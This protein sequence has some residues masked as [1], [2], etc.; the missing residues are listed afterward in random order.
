MRSASWNARIECGG[1]IGAG[2][3]I[4]AHHVLTCAHVVKDSDRHQVSVTFAGGDDMQHAGRVVA[5]GDWDGTPTSQG[6][7]AVLELVRPANLTPAR[8]AAPSD[9][10]GDPPP[11]LLAHGFPRHNRRGTL[12][13]YRTTADQLLDSEW[14]QL[15]AWKTYGQPLAPG[16]SG[17][18]LT[19]TDG[20][21]V[22]LVT[23]AAKDPGI[24]DGRM[25]PAHVVARY[26][27]PL[28]ELIPHPVYSP[29]QLRRLRELIE[30]ASK[31][32]KLQCSPERL[33]R[34]A[35]G[36]GPPPPNG[37]NTLWDAAWYLLFEVPDPR[38]IARFTGRLA[39]F[40]DDLG[41][42]RG[43]RAWSQAGNGSVAPPRTSR[44]PDWSPIL[45][46]I[47]PSGRG[48][49][50][51]LVEVS[52]YNGQDRLVVGSNRL[53][54]ED[55][56][57]YALERIDEAYHVLEPEARELIAFVLPLRYL[58]LDVARWQRSPDDDS[59]LGSFAPLVVIS[60]ERRRSFGLQHKLRQKWARL[61]TH[62]MA[63]LHRIGCA[64]LRQSPKS[65][66]IGLHRSTDMVG[67]G[68]PPRAEGVRQLLRATLNAPA[69]AILWPRNNC[70][71]GAAPHDDCQGTAFL[72]HLDE[73][74][75][76]RPLRDLPAYIHELR[77]AACSV[78][79]GSDSR[80]TERHWAHDLT[81]MW[82]DPRCLP[83]P[84]SFQELP[85]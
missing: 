26:W 36:I 18:A 83:D 71:G 29:S 34:D 53:P 84:D 23:S 63:Q 25:L 39:I 79:D 49:N 44:A 85:V 75:A 21:V 67:F 81:L 58:N 73:Q 10:F 77:E 3:L 28:A 64:S 15:E 69:P 6:D 9:A 70:K 52:A 74:L 72:N 45:V 27:S 60:L 40:I 32:D 35:V 5:R 17:A 13:E 37:L 55:I 19:L 38:A 42:R 78:E 46:E 14:I 20:R 7:V 66:T 16:F 11:K 2:F 22:G 31:Q 1:S 12:T 68:T 50:H 76:G 4:N 65:L 80:A 41:T 62:P 48:N 43:L 33:Y 47:A 51:F 57:A 56:R 54:V 30:E 82:E 8:F 59:P 61:D 24:R